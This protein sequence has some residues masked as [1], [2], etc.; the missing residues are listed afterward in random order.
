VIALIIPGISLVV[1][2]IVTAAGWSFS[3]SWKFPRPSRCGAGFAT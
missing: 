3:A 1:L 2:A